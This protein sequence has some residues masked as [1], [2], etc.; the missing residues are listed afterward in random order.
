IF[1]VLGNIPYMPKSHPDM[2]TIFNL[3]VM[4]SV[5]KGD[6]YQRAWNIFGE[7]YFWTGKEDMIV[8]NDSGQI[9]VHP[10]LAISQP[11]HIP[12]F[13]EEPYVVYA[14]EKA[15]SARFEHGEKP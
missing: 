14:C 4:F 3:P 2:G 15:R 6:L 9:F 12:D 11:S 8:A 7:H 13:W 10:N 1:S 5:H